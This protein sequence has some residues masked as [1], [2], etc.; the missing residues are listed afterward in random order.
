MKNV[1]GPVYFEFSLV[2]K[3]MEQSVHSSLAYGTRRYYQEV[4]FRAFD[5]KVLH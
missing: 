1:S 5:K 3:K 2:T 4:I